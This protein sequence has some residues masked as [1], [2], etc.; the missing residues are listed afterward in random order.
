MLYHLVAHDPIYEKTFVD[1]EWDFM[2]WKI[3]EP[4]GIPNTG[5]R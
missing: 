2:N 4:R 3:V 1:N 5:K